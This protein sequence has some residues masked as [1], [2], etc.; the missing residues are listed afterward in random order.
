MKH[1]DINLCLLSS[2]KIS[3]ANKGLEMRVSRMWMACVHYPILTI[4]WY[5]PE[6]PCITRNYTQRI[7]C[8]FCT[9]LSENISILFPFSELA[10][11]V[12]AHSLSLI[13]TTAFLAFFC[14]LLEASL[15]FPGHSLFSTMTRVARALGIRGQA[16]GML[17]LSQCTECS[18]TKN[19][20]APNDSGT[21]VGGTTL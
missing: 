19:F 18:H 2:S 6:S 13:Y 5:L 10:S 7:H 9:F 4:F 16:P 17:N 8:V 11:W 1:P 15:C 21:P 12:K 14:L 3:L 20:P